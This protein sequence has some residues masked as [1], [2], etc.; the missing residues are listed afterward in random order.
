MALEEGA[1]TQADTTLTSRAEQGR[2]HLLPKLSKAGS[3]SA[4]I[5]FLWSVLQFTPPG[6]C[7]EFLPW[8]LSMTECDTLRESSATDDRVQLPL[9]GES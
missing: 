2:E 7:L 1:A 9:C 8:L 4:S 5:I 6:S 3:K